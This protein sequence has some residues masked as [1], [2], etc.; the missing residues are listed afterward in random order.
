MSP[1]EVAVGLP[2]GGSGAG[3]S[4]VPGF[5][6]EDDDVGANDD[7]MA[8]LMQCGTVRVNC[9]GECL[10]VYVCVCVS[11]PFFS[12]CYLCVSLS[13]CARSYRPTFAHWLFPLAGAVHP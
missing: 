13:S 7:P 4:V 6:G 1:D 12:L 2:V 10:C 9:V 8:P 3:P 5:D 11:R